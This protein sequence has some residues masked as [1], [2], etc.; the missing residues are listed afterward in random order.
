[1]RQNNMENKEGRKH[2]LMRGSKRAKENIEK[3]EKTQEDI[4]LAVFQK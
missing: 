4:W 2:F 3:Q 1:M